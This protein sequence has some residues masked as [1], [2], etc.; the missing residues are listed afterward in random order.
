MPAKVR[1]RARS[2]SLSND[3]SDER[4]AVPLEEARQRLAD[5]I[6]ELIVRDHRRRAVA[7]QKAGD[8]SVEG[9]A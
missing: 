7:E 2:R 1:L 8:P 5:D 4:P 9:K 6:A 3:V